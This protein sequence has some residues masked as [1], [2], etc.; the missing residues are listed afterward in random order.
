M[1]SLDNQG[2]CILDLS[3][4]LSQVDV[5]ALNDCLL[6]VDSPKPYVL[7]PEGEKSLLEGTW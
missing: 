7:V 4:G 6:I 5:G 2:R 1:S 3:I